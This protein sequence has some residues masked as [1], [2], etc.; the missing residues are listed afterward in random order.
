MM[1]AGP[2]IQS[3]QTVTTLTSLLDVYPTLVELAGGTPAEFLRGK[4][5]L[6]LASRNRQNTKHA[7]EASERFI[8]AQYHSNM[9]NTG[10]FMV[11]WKQWK[12]I[13]FGTTLKAFSGYKPQLF[14]V[15]ADP[16]EP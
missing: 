7:S 1:L 4:S 13:V 14:D 5:L 12:Y 11:R 8:T 2:G 15:D 9:G 10:S 16:E 3:G 6:P